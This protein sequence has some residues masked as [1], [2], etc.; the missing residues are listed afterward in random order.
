MGEDKK[1]AL[2]NPLQILIIN[3]HLKPNLLT[4]EEQNTKSNLFIVIHLAFGLL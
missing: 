1:S 3:S 4:K 2:K